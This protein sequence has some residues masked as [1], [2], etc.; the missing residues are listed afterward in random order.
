[1]RFWRVLSCTPLLFSLKQFRVFFLLQMLPGHFI[2]W[3]CPTHISSP[4][5]NKAVVLIPQCAEAE[6]SSE[7]IVENMLVFLP[8]RRPLLFNPKVALLLLLRT[9]STRATSLPYVCYFFKIRNYL[10]TFV[11]CFHCLCYYHFL[12]V[13]SDF[14]WRSMPQ[15][16][17]V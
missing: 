15:N 10:Q 16:S 4:C 11:I 6:E 17:S 3:L 14:R 2:S 1:M 12:S 7:N 8:V 13:T 9:C 5:Q